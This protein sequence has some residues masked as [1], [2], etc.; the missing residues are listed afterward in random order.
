MDVPSECTIV[1]TTEWVGQSVG[2][3]R[4]VA[5]GSQE[6]KNTQKKKPVKREETRKMTRKRP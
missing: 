1:K 3:K 2:Q 4:S 6:S 5:G